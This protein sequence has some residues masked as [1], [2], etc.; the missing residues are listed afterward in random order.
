MENYIDEIMNLFNVLFE[1]QKQK[2]GTYLI[3]DDD[4][5]TM[6]DE[7]NEKLYSLDPS[8]KGLHEAEVIYHPDSTD[9]NVKLA[10]IVKDL[11]KIA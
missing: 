8:L 4:L 5:K 1:N 10:I 9:D 7:I 2:D 11:K 6:S 3:G